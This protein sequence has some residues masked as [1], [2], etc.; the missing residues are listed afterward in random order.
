MR[1]DVCKVRFVGTSSGKDLF[2]SK[3]QELGVCAFLKTSEQR[4]SSSKVETLL[5][6]KKLASE[7]RNKDPNDRLSSS[8]KD[9]ENA[10][11][12]LR[13]QDRLHH[14]R[15]RLHRTREEIERVLPFGLFSM[16]RVRSLEAQSSLKLRF[17]QR[18]HSYG[19]RPI[20]PNYF[21]VDGNACNGMDHFVTFL[22]T[23]EVAEDMIEVHIE[24]SLSEL[25]S[26][27]QEIL[28]EIR[29]CEECLGSLISESQVLRWNDALCLALDGQDVSQASSCI[30]FHLE[31]RLF[32]VDGWVPKH[33]LPLIQDMP[34]R[35]DL[36]I[37]WYL[38]TIDEEEIVPTYLENEGWRRIGED[39]V[40]MYDT[41]SSK[42]KDPSSWVLGGFTLFFSMILA[43]AG[44]GVFLLLGA[45]FLR[46]KT[47]VQER[48]V[49]L[50]TIL[51]C[52]SVLWG[53]LT[54]SLFGFSVSPQSPLTKW[55]PLYRVVERKADGILQQGG[56][57]LASWK[58]QFPVLSRVKTGKEALERCVLTVGGSPEYVMQRDLIQSVMMEFS[59]LVGIL[60]IA[61]SLLR[62]SSRNWAALGWLITLVGG[63]LWAPGVLD[64][65]SILC[66][67]TQWLPAVTEWVGGYLILGG[68]SIAML[69][70][71]M[72]Y[73]IKGAFELLSGVQLFSDVLS[74]LRLYALAVAGG[75]MAATFNQLGREAGFWV[76][77]FIIL[78]GHMVNFSLALMSAVI[79]G[80]RLNFLEWYRYSFEGEGL[81]FLPLRKRD[82]L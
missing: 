49:G 16:E 30:E 82:S 73:G 11:E 27:E 33:H 39:L 19:D 24:R 38:L 70:S 71:C 74:Y 35:E 25:R 43:D 29:W 76:G 21:L 10:E 26:E 52:G 36:P 37:Y 15:D 9:F 63:Y 60:H 54:L 6:A 2:F 12:A 48:I 53:T 40:E 13:A 72:Q 46:W 51:G 7:L 55:S 58:K 78:F 28:I 34:R 67:Y 66:L 57:T 1:K 20:P 50:I 79:H 45:F 68:V 75:I 32:S 61:T 77:I 18:S 4:V 59:I 81:K 44:Y 31:E 14:L 62:Y 22:P 23:K 41:P 17:F 69:L 42:D 65:V 3:M 56:A 64:A 47:K 5:Q 8:Y 80:L